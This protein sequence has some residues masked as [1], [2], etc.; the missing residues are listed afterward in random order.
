[1]H[2]HIIFWYK[3]KNKD[4]ITNIFT[5]FVTNIYIYIYIYIYLLND[6][7]IYHYLKDRETKSY[8]SKINH[9]ELKFNY[10]N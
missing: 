6:I 3:N 7:Y 8:E 4:I 9:Y 5:N 1:M 2:L 10:F